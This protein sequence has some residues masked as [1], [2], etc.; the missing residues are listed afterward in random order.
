MTRAPG[1]EGV[2]WATGTASAGIA[3][4][5]QDD[6]LVADY[7]AFGDHLVLESSM[8]VPVGDATLS[9]RIRR[10]GRTT[11][12]LEL[13]IDG[14]EC[15]RCDLPMFMGVVSGVGASIGRDYGSAVSDRYAAPFAFSGALHE[16]GIQ[17]APRTRRDNANTARAEMARQ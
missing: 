17:L 8:D 10:T 14:A 4:F 5:V 16:V 2:I 3:V 1:D 12:T 15:G 6:R 7:N 9:M 13:A 11:G